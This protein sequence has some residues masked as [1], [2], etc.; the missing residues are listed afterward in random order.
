MTSKKTRSIK[1]SNS[2]IEKLINA[3]NNQRLT[4][5]SIAEKAH[6]SESTV[7]RFCRGNAVDESCASV[8]TAALNLELKD[9]IE[10]PTFP[11]Q[12]NNIETEKKLL[13][14]RQT[15]QKMLREKRQLTTNPLTTGDGTTFDRAEIYVP[16]GLVERKGQPKRNSN[17]TAENG[18]ELYAPTDYEITK[19]LELNQFFEE[20][21]RQGHTPKSQGKRI[22]IIGEPGAGKTTL[23]QH[24]GEWVFAET[25]QDVVIW[26]SL[27]D[28]DGKTI[29]E[30]LLQVWLKDAF[31]TA[32]VKPEMEDA[33]VELFNRESVWLLL[34]GVDEMA[35]ENALGVV[36][37]QLKSWVGEARTI[38]SC[39]LNVWDGGKNALFN[40]DVYRNLDFSERQVGEFIGK[41]FANLELGKKLNRELKKTGKERIINLVKNPLRLALLCYS[42]QRRQ[43]KLPTTKA[44]LYQRFVEIFYEWKEEIFPTTSA[45]RK[46][47]NLA[48]GKL[49]QLAI[50]QTN[51]RFRLSRSLV[52]QILGETDSRLFQL[53]IKLG[54]LNQVGVAAENPESPVYAFFHPTFQEYFAALAVENWQF[55]FKH[56][57]DNPNQGIYRIFQPEWK[58][59]FLLW[60]GREDVDESQRKDFFEQLI[61]FDDCCG[62]FYRIKAY[63]IAQNGFCELGRCSADY[64]LDRVFQQCRKWDRFRNDWQFIHPWRLGFVQP[65]Q[66]ISDPEKVAIL[67]ENL[68]ESLTTNTDEKELRKIFREIGKFG[69]GD[70]QAVRTLLQLLESYISDSDFVCAEI[71]QTLGIIAI[72]TPEVIDAL[73]KLLETSQDYNTLLYSMRSLQVLGVENRKVIDALI[74]VL[75]SDLKHNFLYCQAADSLWKVNPGNQAAINCLNNLIQNTKD[76][77]DRVSAA[78]ILGE[79]N[80]QNSLA[81]ST[82]VNELRP[83]WMNNKT[84]IYLKNPLDIYTLI[85]QV[86]PVWVNHQISDTINA[87]LHIAKWDKLEL[88]KLLHPYEVGI[89]KIDYPCWNGLI[90]IKNNSNV[91]KYSILKIDMPCCEKV[92]TISGEEAQFIK[93]IFQGNFAAAATALEKYLPEY[94]AWEK[95]YW[96]YYKDIWEEEEVPDWIYT[97]EEHYQDSNPFFL[98]RTPGTFVYELAENFL[99]SHAEKM[100]YPD[101]YQLFFE[102]IGK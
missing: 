89:L 63:F 41:W 12:T 38:L 90:I 59:I 32:R 71:A 31:Q 83:W 86:R 21:L 18:S 67:L 80:P 20:V 84:I 66:E 22:A 61:N 29:E 46:E 19:T 44:A 30:Y 79:I 82:L 68:T 16:L 60:L 81:I 76:N 49:A 70:F 34:D 40:F 4:F 56:I 10:S 73:V 88:I 7:K 26:V 93:E 51:S 102:Q 28:L 65:S 24:I 75:K 77:S 25:E 13:I 45:I 42:W 54:W 58:Q 94:Q 85:N 37:S 23:L 35:V 62:N 52:F 36:A 11:P 53:T 43:G 98:D 50:S 57:P 6:V 8:I 3:K 91:D 5:P 55:F 95:N 97:S 14:H 27:A 2:G 9:I 64:P 99:W 69:Y 47:L 17:C 39:R 100:N 72:G 74:K 78:W 33:L 48:L 92:L 101:F 15:C 1:A 87:L 96:G